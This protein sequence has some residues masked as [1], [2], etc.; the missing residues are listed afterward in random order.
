MKRCKYEDFS[1]FNDDMALINKMQVMNL[2]AEITTVKKWSSLRS[3][4]NGF[5]SATEVID[6]DDSAHKLSPPDYRNSFEEN[7]VSIND[8]SSTEDKE[9]N[10]TNQGRTQNLLSLPSLQNRPKDNTAASP[11][12]QNLANCL[13]T[14]H[15][16]LSLE[17]TS[18]SVASVDAFTSNCCN[19]EN[20]F[21]IVLGLQSEIRDLKERAAKT[22]VT[23]EPKTVTSYL[24]TPSETP[25]KTHKHM[26]QPVQES[27]PVASSSQKVSD[28]FKS[29]KFSPSPRKDQ[30]A[31][32]KKTIRDKTFAISSSQ[33]IACLKAERDEKK[34]L[35]EEKIKKRESQIQR[36]QT[37]RQEIEPQIKKKTARKSLKRS[38]SNTWNDQ[39]LNSSMI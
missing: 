27:S 11:V 39:V 1:F 34:R 26:Q 20:L 3:S 18:A 19:V 30:G 23:P 33:G 13:N 35:E 29:F 8:M 16:T 32:K 36:K 22:P 4:Y 10:F 31:K 14:E 9:T 37:V 12:D 2:V 28:I 24:R 7:E 38:F 5:E 21:N 25:C 15:S 17:Q 6:F